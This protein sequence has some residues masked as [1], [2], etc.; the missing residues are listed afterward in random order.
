MALLDCMREP[1]RELLWEPQA[2]VTE[3]AYGT[4]DLVASYFTF[5][6]KVGLVV[7]LAYIQAAYGIRACLQ[8]VKERAAELVKT[9][10]QIP[11]GRYARTVFERCRE[12][13]VDLYC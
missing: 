3:R 6:I 13:I 4:F 1:L 12:V 9:V 8:S 10:R 2:S 11:W 7:V 5:E